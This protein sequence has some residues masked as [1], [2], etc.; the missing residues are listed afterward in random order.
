MFLGWSLGAN[1][2]ANI[3]GTAVGSR[4]VKFKTAAITSSLF[5]LMG[6]ILGGSGTT[7]TLN[8]LGKV[9]EL[10]DAAII[11]FS[12]A[13]IVLGMTWL[14][15]PVSTSQAIIGGII[16]WNVFNGVKTNPEILTKIISTWI[17]S[18]VLSGITAI[19]CY[20]VFKNLIV[21]IKL[22]LLLRDQIIRKSLIF[23]G[24]LGAYSLGANNIANVM[25]IFIHSS[26]LNDLLLFNTYTIPVSFQLYCLGGLAISAGIITYSKPVMLTVG[27]NLLKLSPEHAL[28]VVFSHSVVLLLFSS[29]KLSMFLSSIGLP[30]IPLVPVS[31]TQAIIGAILGLGLFKSSSS[32]KFRKLGEIALSWVLAPLLTL[33][34]CY[35][36][37]AIFR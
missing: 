20:L 7:E 28:I 14:K 23:I 4:M 22:H 37:F 15:L 30:Q 19:I 3:F 9:T 1:D 16:G 29:V 21:K 33:L 27:K 36:L 8:E 25:G 26:G 31:S 32:L 11:S 34:F 35:L 24:A 2:A 6:S 18:P 13:S 12:A 17:F 10:K 5:V